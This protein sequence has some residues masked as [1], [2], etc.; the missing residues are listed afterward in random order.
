ML[1]LMATFT[2]MDIHCFAYRQTQKPSL[3]QKNLGF[4]DRWT[5]KNIGFSVGFGYCNNTKASECQRTVVS[6]LLLLS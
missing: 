5:L 4:G 3:W 2:G 6:A 1:L